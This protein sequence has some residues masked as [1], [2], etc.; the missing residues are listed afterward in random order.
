MRPLISTVLASEASLK[1]SSDLQEQSTG[2]QR[3][4]A[5]CFR[6]LSPSPFL[7]LFDRTANLNFGHRSS[8]LARSL[9]SRLLMSRVTCCRALAAVDIDGQVAVMCQ[10]R[11]K[12]AD[13]GGEE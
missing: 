11:P 6:L 3:H 7:N 9:M 5:S 1:G 12:S 4:P 2:V 10:V 8:V 13:G